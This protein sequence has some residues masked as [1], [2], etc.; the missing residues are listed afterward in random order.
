MKNKD[1]VIFVNT[2]IFN[3]QEVPEINKTAFEIFYAQCLNR[4][5]EDKILFMG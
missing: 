2:E 5:G 1:N 3:N 4:S